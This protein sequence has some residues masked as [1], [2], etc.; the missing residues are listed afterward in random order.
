MEHA[1]A[2]LHGLKNMRAYNT[3][4]SYMGKFTQCSK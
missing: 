3:I 2:V 4:T 1:N